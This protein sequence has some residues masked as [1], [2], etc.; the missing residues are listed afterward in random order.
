MDTDNLSPG[1]TVD[2]HVI[3]CQ[4]REEGK[5]HSNSLY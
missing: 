2:S 1:H 5:I 3:R 4:D